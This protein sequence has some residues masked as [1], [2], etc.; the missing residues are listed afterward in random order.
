MIATTAKQVSDGRQTDVGMGA[1]VHGVRGIDGNRSK[2]VKKHERSDM[3]FADRGQHP[4]D[5]Q[6]ADIFFATF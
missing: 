3:L 6:P 4:P 5:D 1:D 2:M